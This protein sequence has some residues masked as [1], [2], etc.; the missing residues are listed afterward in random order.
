[1]LCKNTEK[2]E[3]DSILP[4]SSVLFHLLPFSHALHPARI[5]KT[6]RQD[7]E[8]IIYITNR[9]RVDVESMNLRAS[10]VMLL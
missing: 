4:F 5:A 3:I 8:D 2:G 10:G 7:K 9:W 6:H 1:M